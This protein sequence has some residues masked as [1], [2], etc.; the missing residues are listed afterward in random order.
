[1][2]FKHLINK[3]I[4]RLQVLLITALCFFC[5]QPVK[6]QG[7]ASGRELGIYMI[8]RACKDSIMLRWAPKNYESWQL[9]NKSGYMIKRY[10]VFKNGTSYKDK[11]PLLLTRQPLKPISVD[12]WEL[13]SEHND[14]AGIAAQ[15]IYGE[16]FDVEAE[17]ESPVV[18]IFNKAT[19]Q[20]NRFSFAMFSADYSA[21]VARG[22]G[23]MYSDKDIQTGEKY[24]YI[25]YFGGA[26]TLSF[27]T[28]FTYTGTDEIIP[29]NKPLITE[30]ISQDKF[31]TLQWMSE[32]GRFGYTSFEVER[33]DDNGKTFQTRN[34]SP[35]INTSEEPIDETLHFFMDSV[36][37]NNVEY[38]YRVR[39]VNPFGEKGPYSDTISARGNEGV[40]T[41]PRIVKHE[42]LENG[43]YIEWEFDKKYENK[44]KGFQVLRSNKSD[45][46]FLQISDVLDKKTRQYNDSDPIPTAYYKV[47]AL[48]K[49]GD[50]LVSFPVLVQGIDSI[51]PLY[52]TGLQATI[53]SSGIV[54]LNWKAN[55]DDDI[56]GYRIYRANASH[57]EFSQLTVAP[58]PDTFFI[59]TVNLKTL[60]SKVCY[61]VMAIDKRQNH[62]GLSEILEVT[63]PDIVPPVS[64]IIKNVFS[65]NQGI[66]LDWVPSSS[67]DVVKQVLLRKKENTTEWEA[68]LTVSDSLTTYCDTTVKEG[69]IYN[70]T[71]M[72]Y[73]DNGLQSEIVR[74]VSGQK[75]NKPNAL[76]LIFK[77]NRYGANIELSWT[78]LDQEGK[79][80]LYRGTSAK[81]LMTY[82]RL[83]TKTNSYTDR[84]IT[85]GETYSYM[86]KYLNG[87]EL[88]VSNVIKV[89]Y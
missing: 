45:R 42:S 71:L 75:Q 6:S 43:S 44:I 10:T 27:D 16:S 66:C 59:D 64:P 70:Y 82:S 18:S 81:P 80:F 40:K 37:Q 69:I 53:D 57:E 25:V 11:N 19:E 84:K 23:L 52:P 77:V 68:I 32:K 36:P 60:S 28:A 31:I 4:S 35:L 85:P 21:E 38:I 5:L 55:T 7:Q 9:G 76:E 58:I 73:D 8:S 62:S 83:D 88:K 20:Q 2:I 78:P 47:M 72:A 79:L 63:R 22:M 33:S 65:N 1:M 39:G 51:P 26:D 61:R 56:Y 87:K 13:M 3:I 46:G 17:N 41:I 89:E 67:S 34:S 49:K 74:V 14:Y 15:S 24:L 12:K 30:A 50:I 54:Y 86:I 29:L 48:S